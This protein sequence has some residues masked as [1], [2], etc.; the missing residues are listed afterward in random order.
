MEAASGGVVS[1]RLLP[2]IDYVARRRGILEDKSAGPSNL[3]ILA[4]LGRAV[5]RSFLPGWPT[6]SAAGGRRFGARQEREEDV[7]GA[8]VDSEGRSSLQSLLACVCFVFFSS[9]KERC[10]GMGWDGMG[11]DSI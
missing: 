7:P 5:H 2:R 3:P 4:I 9:E 8:G 1:A 11:W 10:L 6:R